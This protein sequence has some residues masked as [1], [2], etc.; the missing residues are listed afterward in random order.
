MEVEVVELWVCLVVVGVDVELFVD[1]VL[2]DVVDEGEVFEFDVDDLDDDE[3]DEVEFEVDVVEVDDGCFLYMV[4]GVIEVELV[5]DGV[6]E[7]YDLDEFDEEVELFIVLVVEV[8]E[9]V[10]CMCYG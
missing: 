10:D 1:E 8:D 6:D 5:E 4:L 2:D 3:V 9:W 7:D